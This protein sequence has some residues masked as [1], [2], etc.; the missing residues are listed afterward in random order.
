MT[1]SD[2]AQRFAEFHLANPEVYTTLV[3]LARTAKRRGLRR[4][5]IRM[6]WERARWDLTLKTD[7]PTTPFKLDDRLT[8]RY[9]R[10]IQQQEPDLAPLFS[11]RTLRS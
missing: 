1:F 8:S 10:L 11:I 9:V 5:G 3:R 6:L 4:I 2:L 7:D